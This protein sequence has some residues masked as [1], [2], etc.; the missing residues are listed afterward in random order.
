MM[1]SDRKAASN[2]MNARKSTGPKSEAGRRRSRRNALRH[3]LAIAIGS[4]PSFGEDIN[5]LAKALMN[6]ASEQRVGEFA[7]Q[8]AEAEIDLQRIR[9]LR[10]SR[11]NIVFGNS[12]PK[13]EDHLKLN[14]DLA[15]LERYERRALSRRKRA[16]LAM[17]EN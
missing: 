15:K 2:R 13:L 6:G 8:A 16:L 11:F 10:A 4:D 1:T 12:E 9:K 7:R 5:I 3:G 17:R 14:E